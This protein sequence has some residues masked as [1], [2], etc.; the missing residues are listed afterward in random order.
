MRELPPE[1]LDEALGRPQAVP[2]NRDVAD[3]RDVCRDGAAAA[4]RGCV[5]GL[6]H[7][8]ARR[9]P[10]SIRASQRRRRRQAA[11]GERAPDHGPGDAAATVLMSSSVVS[12]PCRTQGGQRLGDARRQRSRRRAAPWAIPGEERAQG[13]CVD[14]RSGGVTRRRARGVTER[15]HRPATPSRVAPRVARFRMRGERRA[16]ATRASVGVRR[17]TAPGSPDSGTAAPNVTDSLVSTHARNSSI[18]S[19]LTRCVQRRP[20]RF[21]S[22]P[23]SVPPAMSVAPGS[24][25]RR[26]TQSSTVAGRENPARGPLRSAAPAA[27]ADRAG[28]QVAADRAPTRRR[29]S[30]DTPYTG[31][32]CRPAPTDRRDRPGRA[33]TA[34][35][36]DSSQTRACNTRTATRPLPPWP[37]GRARGGRSG[38]RLHREISWCAARGS[39]MR[40]LFTMRYALAASPCSAT[41]ATAQAP[42]SPS[43][44]PSLAP[45]R[46]RARRKSRSVT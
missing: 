30:D 2:S 38:Q 4:D 23:R 8:T 10:P 11:R 39:G 44:H 20:P 21:D 28:R 31:R 32:G 22:T 41:N 46:P 17:P 13:T 45:V 7:R 35:R 43:A 5:P 12:P 34:R 42:H 36:R 16:P 40:Q 26:A 3:R 24:A 29:E 6:T 18:A 14:P 37:P 15:R 33:D 1:L 9:R 19:R 25:A 27:R